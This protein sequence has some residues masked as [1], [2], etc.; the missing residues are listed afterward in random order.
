MVLCADLNI[1]GLQHRLLPFMESETLGQAVDQVADS[2]VITDREGKIEYVNPAFSRMTG[3]SPE[4]AIGATPRLVRSGKQDQPFYQNLWST[5]RS[6]RTWRG[7]LINRR[8]NGSL[9]TEEMVITPV[10]DDSGAITNFIAIK[11]DI[12]ERRAAEEAQCFLGSLLAATADAIVGVTLDGTIMSWNPSAEKLYGF[13]AKEIIGTPVS[14]LIPPEYWEH[15]NVNLAKIAE[16]ETLSAFEGTGVTREGRRFDISLSLSPVPDRSGKVIGAAAII[17]DITRWKRAQEETAFLASLVQTS[18][19]AIF[20]LTPDGTITSWNKGAEMIFGYTDDEAVG[21]GISNLVPGK[22]EAEAP[23]ILDALEQGQNLTHLET[24]GRT[25]DGGQVDIS[26]SISPIRNPGGRNVALAATAH[27]ITTRKQNERDLRASESRYRH[28]F[29]HN[30]AGVVRTNLDGRVLDCNPALVRM[31]GYT[32]ENIPNAASVYYFENDRARLI[33]RLKTERFVT[34]QE[35]KFRRKD[36]GALW[37][38]ANL[39]LTDDENGG[40]LEATLIDITD[41]KRSEEDREMAMAAA[42]AANRA[43]SEFL[44]NMSHEI[45]TPMNGVMGMT[46]VLL[47]TELTSEQREYLSIVKSSADSLLT[48]INDILDFSKVEAG[49]LELE[50][51]PFDL[52]AVVESAAKSLLLTAHDKGLDLR[53]HIEPEVPESLIGDSTRVRQVLLNVMN[54]AIKFTKQGSVAVDVFAEGRDTGSVAL[55]FI[56]S[57]TGIGIP[58]DKQ[59]AIFE[60]FVQ[61]DSSSTRKFGGTGLGLAISSGLVKAM[62]GNIWVESEPGMGSDFHFRIRLG[63]VESC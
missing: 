56:V 33:E 49:K 32:L 31:L 39:A 12:T 25:K 35:L 61:G 59:K 15:L 22:S 18:E 4:D 57:D 48:V 10:R 63:R 53:W 21:K 6:G 8:K 36:G 16:G 30:L 60:A 19:D 55:H 24:V 28:L 23:R 20:G 54:N 7:D 2:V 45:R 9:Y 51:V 50:S 27:N 13:L 29:E 14:A 52:P 47:D 37:V 41:R 34:N 26:L 40:V 58:H 5:I 38:L 44:A 46:A 11:Q 43:K 3:Y 1:E 17:R 62:D 42:Q